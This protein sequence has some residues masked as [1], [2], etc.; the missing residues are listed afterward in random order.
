MFEKHN[1]KLRARKL[2]AADPFARENGGTLKAVGN[3]V[4]ANYNTGMHEGLNTGIALICNWK[5]NIV[6]C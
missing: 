5:I 6:I 2:A 1:S 3:A 4:N